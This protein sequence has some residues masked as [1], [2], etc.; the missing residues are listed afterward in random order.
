YQQ[1]YITLIPAVESILTFSKERN[2]HLEIITNT[3]SNRQ[4]MQLTH[5]NIENFVDKSIIFISSE[6]GFSKRDTNIFRVAVYV[7]NLDRENTYYVGDYYRNDVLG[8]KKAGWK[9][10]WLN[11]S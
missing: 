6:F 11:H 3:P 9:S 2:I 4:I 8:A 5:L 10:I 1:S 7:M